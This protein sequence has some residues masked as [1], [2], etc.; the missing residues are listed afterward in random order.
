MRR[1][2]EA[3]EVDLPLSEVDRIHPAA[4]VDTDEVWDDLVPHGHRR[5]DRAPLAPVDIGHDADARPLREFIVT[6]AADLRDRFLL[7]HLCVCNRRAAASANLHALHCHPPYIFFSF[8]PP[9]PQRGRGTAQAVVG[10]LWTI[11]PFLSCERHTRHK[12]SYRRCAPLP[13]VTTEGS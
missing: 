12:R 10:V 3:F 8:Q 5:A 9:L 2:I 7:D 1:R 4:D 13:P 6:H 11:H